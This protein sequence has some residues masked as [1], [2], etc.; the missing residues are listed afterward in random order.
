M[1]PAERGEVEWVSEFCPVKGSNVLTYPAVDF[2][3]TQV[4]T[5]L[6]FYHPFKSLV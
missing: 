5:K 4:G 1:D 6:V 2:F 3:V